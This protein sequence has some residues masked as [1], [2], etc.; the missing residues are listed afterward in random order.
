MEQLFNPRLPEGGHPDIHL[1][2]F[3]HLPEFLVIDSRT[4]NP[5]VLVLNTEDVFDED[6]YRTVETD[7]SGALRTK[8]ESLFSHLINLPIVMDETIRDIAM[9]FILNKLG[10]HVDE[11]DDIPSVVVY[12][13]SGGALATHTGSI[14]AGINDLIHS[15]FNGS[16]STC[17]EQTVAEL[18]QWETDVLVK[19]NEQ[20]VEEALKG[21]SPD[22]FTLWESR[23]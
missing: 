21:D 13:V 17:W 8:K 15:S 19:I 23:N 12:V 3:P 7:F 10:V 6:F 22:Y 4:D 9:T 18:V 20:Q 1:C 16:E 5:Q 2:I 14:L 11:E